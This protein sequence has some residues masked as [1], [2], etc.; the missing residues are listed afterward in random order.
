MRLTVIDI[1]YDSGRLHERMGRGPGHFL[2][3]G[4]IGRLEA[5]GHEVGTAPVRLPDDFFPAEVAAAVELH[6]RISRAVTAARDAGRLPVLLSG[7]CNYAALG[8]LAA[9]SPAATGVVWLD[10]HAD[11]NTPDTSPSGFLDGMALSM[12]T[13]EAYGPA[14]ETVP[15]LAPLPHRNVVL[16]GVRDVDPAEGER[17]ERSALGWLEVETLRRQGLG[18]AL[19]AA[20]DDLPEVVYLHVDLDVLDPSVGRV[21]EFATEGGLTLDELRAVAATV[22]GQSQVAAV[23]LTAYDPRFDGDGRVF[24]AGVAALEALVGTR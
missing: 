13:G 2:A 20:L 23:A 19:A 11:F 4:L 12:A 15:G 16:L 22:S 1:P 3:R 8:T 24:E 14:L 9:L 21:N 10:A 18:E 17:V 5:A 7:N 6:R